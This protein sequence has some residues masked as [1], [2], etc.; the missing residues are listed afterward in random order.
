[1]R[2]GRRGVA[3]LAALAAIALLTVAV[4]VIAR[5]VIPTLSLHGQIAIAIGTA[6]V[7]LL[8]AAL[9]A[10]MFYSNRSGW[11]DIDREIDGEP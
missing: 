1:M 10:L 3:V 9:M 2:L 11:D 8:S 5:A 6:G 4:V 7:S